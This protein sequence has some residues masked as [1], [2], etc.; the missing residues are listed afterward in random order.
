MKYQPQPWRVSATSLRRLTACGLLG[1]TGTSICLAGQHGPVP[2]G[3]NAPIAPGALSHDIFRMQEHNAEAADFIIYE[4]EFRVEPC[5][6]VTDPNFN[7]NYS[8][9]AAINPCDDTLVGGDVRLNYAGEDHVKQI[10][11]R[12]QSGAPFPVLIE[13][14]RHSR[15]LGDT[16]KLPVHLNPQLD[17]RR[18][19]VI[20][21][22]LT[23]FGI[24]NA[25]DVV[26]VSPS[27]VEG[28]TSGEAERSYL[29][30]INPYG[31]IGSSGGR[32]RAG[33]GF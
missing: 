6:R 12:L 16:Y 33:F 22:A 32:G 15:R 9:K 11:A 23:A 25:E 20:V 18:R 28:F 8:R 21:H 3:P 30:G 24:Q 2:G 29:R 19:E 13:R 26:V 1:L 17:M 5:A 4:H 7:D 10:A 27:F 14:S 31:G